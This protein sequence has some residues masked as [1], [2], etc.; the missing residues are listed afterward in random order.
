M[1]ICFTISP[2]TV[3]LCP[4]PTFVSV[5]TSL[6]LCLCI[7]VH[8]FVNIICPF[9]CL[10][11]EGDGDEGL[12]CH[13]YPIPSLSTFNSN[14]LFSPITASQRLFLGTPVSENT[15]YI[16]MP[17][18]RYTP[19]I[20]KSVHDMYNSICQ[21]LQK[22]SKPP[23]SIPRS[24]YSDIFSYE[25]ISL[26]NHTPKEMFFHWMSFIALSTILS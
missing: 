17:P 5:A 12:T 2:L 16:R 4:T 1:S 24:L 9:Q 19:P 11:W 6:G 23:P 18:F 25:T 22:V 8:D 14:I 15:S 21:L 10:G 20:S 7:F 13:F 3:H 26:C